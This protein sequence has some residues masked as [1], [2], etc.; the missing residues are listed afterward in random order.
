MALQV[1]EA[2]F[3]SFG[4]ELLVQIC[5][6]AGEGDI[7]GAAVAV[8]HRI[9]EEALT[10]QIVVQHFG[11]G[12]VD[13]LHVGKTAD[14]VFQILE[15]Q[16]GHIDAPAGGRVVH[17]VLA[18]Q[19]G[20]VHHGGH[21]VGSMAQQVVA[22]DGNCH[23][24]GSYI[25]LHAEVDAAVLGHIHGLGEDHGAHVGYQR[26][27]LHL[28]HLH[29]LGAEDG[30]VLADV[31]I[32]GILIIVD[33]VHVRDVG[34]VLVLAGSNDVH[35]A[36]LGGFLGGK[37]REVAGDKV[38][39]FAGGHEIQRDHGKLLGGTALK[40]TDLV[41]V[42]NVHYPAQGG[43]G[44][45]DDG[46][47]PLAAVAHLHHALTA[48]AILEQLCLCLPEHLLGQHAGACAEVVNS[49]H[50]ELSLSCIAQ[51]RG[52][53]RCVLLIAVAVV[54]RFCRDENKS[55]FAQRYGAK[56]P[57]RAQSTQMS[58]IE[59]QKQRQM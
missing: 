45:L 9:R 54:Y 28:R 34:E 39:C 19:G 58:L 57:V 43:L 5:I 6:G 14:V 16:T 4:A 41:V 36:E 37:V 35:L 30:V 20:V 29:E 56:A 17:A 7:H 8:L 1:H 10:V 27:T 47:E 31:D 2:C 23:A 18:Q 22:D 50:N 26:H 33:G 24:G 48:V 46:I 25:L 44:V 53:L 11:L 49:C 52:F 42:G 32:A 3:C 59:K 38:I 15:H 55:I 40:E 51:H 21:I 13:L 12:F